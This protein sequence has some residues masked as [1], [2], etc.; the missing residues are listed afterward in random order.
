MLT[1]KYG[2]KK[3]IR[4]LIVGLMLLMA[5]NANANDFDNKY[6]N[7]K[8]RSY[9]DAGYKLEDFDAVFYQKIKNFKCRHMGDFTLGRE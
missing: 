8:C 5:G 7:Q 2:G 9:V 4:F 3:M 6:L 1:L